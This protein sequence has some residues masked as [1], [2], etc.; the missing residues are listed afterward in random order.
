MVAGEHDIGQ[1]EGR[2][3]LIDE[4]VRSESECDLADLLEIRIDHFLN[5]FHRGLR[6]STA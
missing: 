6:Q 3:R 5:P 1:I 4:M 2:Q